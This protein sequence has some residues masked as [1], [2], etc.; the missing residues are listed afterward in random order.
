MN[1]GKAEQLAK[2]SLC[3]YDPRRPDHAELWQDQEVPEPRNNCHCDACYYGRDKLAVAM[4]EIIK[5]IKNL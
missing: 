4:L 3:W 2:E 5:L 1:L